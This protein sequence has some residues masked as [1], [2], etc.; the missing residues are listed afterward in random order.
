MLGGGAGN[1]TLNNCTL[2]GNSANDGGGAYGG[3]LNNCTLTGNSADEAG[4][5]AYYGHAE[6][7]HT[8]RQLG[9]IQRRRGL[10]AAR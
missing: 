7:L 9:W 8:D 1:G 6:Q 3:T 10:L 5:G 2:T 4:G